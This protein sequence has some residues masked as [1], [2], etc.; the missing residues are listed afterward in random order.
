MKKTYFIFIFLFLLNNVYSQAPTYNWTK[1]NYGEWDDYATAV[2]TDLNGNVIEAGHFKS[3]DYFN[4]QGQNL[5]LSSVISGSYDYSDSYIVKY[6]SNGNALWRVKTIG[7]YAERILSVTTD[8]QGN[9]YATGYYNG[10]STTFGSI[11]VNNT[12]NFFWKAFIMKLSP[13]GTVLWV[14]TEVSSVGL[15]PN[16][17]PGAG[18]SYTSIK[19]DINGNIFVSGKLLASSITIGTTT[20][21]NNPDLNLVSANIVFVKYDSDGNVVWAKTNQGGGFEESGRLDI[22]TLGNV[23]AIGSSTSSVLT[24]N[25]TSATHPGYEIVPSP[26]VLKMDNDGNTVWLKR[27]GGF[28]FSDYGN[29]I[30][31]DNIGNVYVCGSYRSSQINFAGQQLTNNLQS[32]TTQRN[33]DLFIAK[34]NSDGIEQWIKGATIITSG[35]FNMNSFENANA[36]NVDDNGCIYLVG[37]F[38]FPINIG[39]FNL[40]N[41]NPPVTLPYDD[42]FIAKFNSTGNVI[43]AKSFGGPGSDEPRKIDLDQNENILIVGFFNSSSS[44]I[45]F[46]N[47]SYV[48]HSGTNLF[49]NDTFITKLNSSLGDCSSLSINNQLKTKTTF[50]F[51]NPSNQIFNVKNDDIILKIN[52]IDF[53]G[54]TVMTK[55]L[56]S[57]EIELNMNSFSNGVYVLEVIKINYEKDF[58]RIIKN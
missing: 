47:N 4:V 36:I 51:P 24:V 41:S 16:T 40:I 46:D 33:P 43:W 44:G 54:R 42:G 39:G 45:T 48:G 58:I 6:D 3:N 14:K 26:F 22:D 29:D 50:V 19:T 28:D 2:A 27:F 56:Q 57:N 37:T 17:T 10:D 20:L 53:L 15:F 11:Q 8:Y 13:T 5:T 38:S 52:V 35:L 7:T 25:T 21:S 32:T 31:I 49:R 34:Y 30:S 23:Y 9:I 55:N 12:G 1:V 18:F